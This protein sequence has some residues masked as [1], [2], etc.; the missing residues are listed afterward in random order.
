MV[1]T[2]ESLQKELTKLIKEI[3]ATEQELAAVTASTDLETLK[4]QIEDKLKE[5]QRETEEFKKKKFHRDEL[6]YQRD[7]VYTWYSRVDNRPYRT[8]RDTTTQRWRSDTEGATSS[9]SA[10]SSSGMTFLERDQQNFGTTAEST[11]NTIQT[12]QGY[13]QDEGNMEAVG[14]YVT[15]SDPCT[16]LS[17]DTEAPLDQFWSGVLSCQH[18]DLFGSATCH[19]HR[20]PHIRDPGA[21]WGIMRQ[22][23]ILLI[24]SY[25]Y[26]CSLD[27]LL[28]D[29]EEQGPSK[30]QERPERAAH[31]QPDYRIAHD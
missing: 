17:L 23:S 26:S 13:P 20:V 25:R 22:L 14:H 19:Q 18:F 29:G 1:L 10:S 7:Q 5:Y 16:V 31:F 21:R 6:D 11:D 12:T 4:K 15:E 8:N 2:I 28:Q 9:S 24:Y 30:G 3:A 27:H